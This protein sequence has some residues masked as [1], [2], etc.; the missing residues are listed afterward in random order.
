VGL[1]GIHTRALSHAQGTLP[2][3]L[4]LFFFF[5]SAFS[6]SVVP[7]VSS[8]H[9]KY[10]NNEFFSITIDIRVHPALLQ[11]PSLANCLQSAPR[12]QAEIASSSCSRR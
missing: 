6:A 11:L 3:A 7:V 1:F 5:F 4:A 12:S 9:N 2:L 10:S 8:H